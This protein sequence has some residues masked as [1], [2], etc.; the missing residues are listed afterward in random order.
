MSY[1]MFI[2]EP[3][4]RLTFRHEGGRRNGRTLLRGVGSHFLDQDDLLVL[5]GDDLCLVA[6]LER[7]L[8][9]RDFSEGD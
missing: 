2:G 7:R 4:H 6:D 1:R 8:H 3:L 5:R 9:G